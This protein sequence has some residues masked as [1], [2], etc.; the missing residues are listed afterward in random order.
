MNFTIHHGDALAV[1]ATL[2]AASFDACFCDPPYHLTQASRGGS[3]RVNDPATPF[4][5]TRLGSKGFM[6]K[7]WDGGDV[8]FRPELWREVLRVL[9][10][11]APLLAFGGTRTFHRLA[12]A[13][14]DAGFILTDTLCWL[15]G[16]GFPKGQAQ[17]KPAWEPITLAW[18][19][20]KRAL[21]I[22]AARIGY[23]STSNPSSNPLYRKQNGYA[24]KAGSDKNGTSWK[25][26]PEDCKITVNALGRWPANVLLD[27]ESAAALDA[28]SGT[29]TSGAN[30]ERRGSDKFRE[31]YSA[32][33]GQRE[34][35]PA[36]G[37]STG[38]ASRFF[39]CAKADT[40]ER[41]NGGQNNHPTVKPIDLCVYLAKL[42]LPP[43][44]DAS[45]RILVP[46]C[47]SGSEIIGALRA[48]WD[49][50]TGIE[51]S[52]EYVELAQRRIVADAPLLNSVD[53]LS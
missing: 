3:P 23:E 19:K 51:I 52:A 43:A 9:K 36:R 30:P 20:G 5:R 10:P 11:G 37:A 17:L 14:E 21:A 34:C 24:M 50:A 41:T 33:A 1:L 7:T 12:C 8:A 25:I 27:E 16:Q 6:G 48:G 47:G 46:F 4:G 2:E 29:L 42:L 38:G 32:F 39:Y 28:Q 35:N 15:H 53:L 22:D 26:K 18:K 40:A 49:E 13:I 31:T 45:R 44:G